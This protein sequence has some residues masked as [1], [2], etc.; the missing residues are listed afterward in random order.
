MGL[1][2]RLLPYRNTPGLRRL[3]REALMLYGCDIPPQVTF[4]RNIHIG[5]RGLGL[6]I[7]PKV[8]VGDNVTIYHGVTIGRATLGTPVGDT[9]IEDGVVISTG[10][11]ITIGPEG[12]TIG[13]GAIIGANAVVTK[14][15]PPGEVWAGVPARK[16]ND[17]PGYSPRTTVQ[18]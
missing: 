13:A 6:V 5:H 10:A 1:I 14:D 2:T 7:Y 16:I 12:R 11:V 3:V 9:V 17:R 4:G 18:A 8:R 15:V